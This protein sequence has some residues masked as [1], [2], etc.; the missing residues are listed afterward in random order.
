MARAKYY[1]APSENDQLEKLIWDKV[2]ALISEIETTIE[3][4]EDMAA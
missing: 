2:E 3:P 1:A 4:D